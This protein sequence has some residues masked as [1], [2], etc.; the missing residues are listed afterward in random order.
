[1]E[2]KI[3]NKIISNDH[4]V[5][6]IAEI[7]VNHNGSVELAKKLVYEA[8]IAGVDAVKF[9][10]YHTDQL[11]T[12][13]AELAGYQQKTGYTSQREMLEQYQLDEEQMTDLKRY[14]DQIGIP[15]L[16]TPFDLK[17][18]RFLQKLNIEA[19]KIGSG[20]FDNYPLLQCIKK[21]NKPMLL[22]TGMSSLKE[23][24]KTLSFFNP[25]QK[26][27]ILHCT[28]AYPAPYEE[29]N[30]HV[31]ATFK[32]HFQQIIGYSDHSIGLEVPFAATALGYKIIE[33]HFTLDK[34]MKGPD[35]RTSLE[36]HELKRMVLGIRR[37]EKALG[38]GEKR[39]T[40]SEKKNKNLVRKGIYA[41]NDMEIGHPLALEDLCFLRPV[42]EIEA[43]DYEK[44]LGKKIQI[45]KRKGEPLFWKDFEGG[46]ES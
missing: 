10:M 27:A 17:S 36:P 8:Y 46:W 16:A 21:Y 31:I 4:E 24:E 13:N 38:N 33:K 44:I 15:F 35:H 12:E 5:F 18:A 41:A 11:V 19:F 45:K 32:K 34:T 9:Q 26:L 39:I 29:L 20:D 25:N 37:I 30:L 14:C 23:I 7:G 2:F 6:I 40:P 28:S 43:K 42:E 1:M 3:G 22:S